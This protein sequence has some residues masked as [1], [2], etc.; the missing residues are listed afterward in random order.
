MALVL[1]KTL[2]GH[3]ASVYKL[4]NFNTVDKFLS[5]AGDGMI[6]QWSSDSEDGVLIAKAEDKLYS[7]CLLH[8]ETLMAGGY[9]GEL[10]CLDINS[11]SM[12]KRV[13]YHKKSIYDIVAT[14][15]NIYVASGD[16]HL[17]IWKGDDF[18]LE[19]DC[20]VNSS[21]LRSLAILG[22]SLLIGGMDGYLYEFNL[23]TAQ[24]NQRNK[25]HLQSIFKVLVDQN[26]V[27]T[28]GRDAH[29]RIF[30]FQFEMKTEVAAHW[31]TVNDLLLVDDQI[32]SV[33]M[34]KKIRV[35]SRDLAKLNQSI[36]VQK[37]GHVNSVN[38]VISLNK[39]GSIVTAGDDRS[40][41]IWSNL[42]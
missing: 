15:T 10:H 8:N 18:T 36:D 7:G 12:I 33:S 25:L 6:V 39:N 27:Y 3:N 4:L 34:D 28:C 22:D 23:M 26:L 11:S 24:V 14:D 40:I 31:Q 19:L 30:N 29:I 1:D 21:G 20:Q 9:S 13:Q 2:T 17:T 41:K 5:L 38:S 42:P 32:V 16:G 37:G 35:W